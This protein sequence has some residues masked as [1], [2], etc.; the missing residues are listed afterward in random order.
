MIYF[1]LLPKV[2]LFNKIPAVHS[3]FFS[4]VAEQSR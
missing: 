1:D 4:L 3:E 2:I